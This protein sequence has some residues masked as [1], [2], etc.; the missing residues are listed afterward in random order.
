MF[1]PTQTVPSRITALCIVL[2]FSLSLAYVVIAMI[3]TAEVG[4]TEEI[5]SQV[6]E[7]S[8]LLSLCAIFTFLA[9]IRPLAGGLALLALGVLV[10]LRLPL[11]GGMVL[12]YSLLCLLRAYTS[13]QILARETATGD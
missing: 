6:S 13:R 4:M 8:G 12:A 9:V 11:A 2:G 7:N 10:A 1:R 3:S 5:R